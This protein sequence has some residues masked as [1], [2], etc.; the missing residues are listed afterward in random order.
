[1]KLKNVLCFLIGHDDPIMDS[2]TYFNRDQ[3]YHL[4]KNQER[5]CRRCGKFL[6]KIQQ[7]IEE[8]I[9]RST[10]SK[11][12]DKEKMIPTLH[13]IDLKEKLNEHSKFL[14]LETFPVYDSGR[15]GFV[16][17]YPDGTQKRMEQVLEERD[18]IIFDH[19]KNANNIPLM[20]RKGELQK[21]AG[22]TAYVYKGD[23]HRDEEITICLD[24][25]EPSVEIE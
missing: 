18:Q 10:Y 7:S 12:Y 15:S 4:W 2:L 11:Q 1:M 5:M 16:V 14:M 21:H 6:K 24:C 20:I 3:I 25:T 19:M 23:F 9:K 17:E 22:H 8:D 13:P